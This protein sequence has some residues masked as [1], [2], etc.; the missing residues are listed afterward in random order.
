MTCEHI[1]QINPDVKPSTTE[2]CEDCLKMNPQG[3]W[4]HLRMCLIC[5]HI[6]CCDSSPNTHARKHFEETGHPIIESF[7]I[8][9]NDPKWRWCY[10]DNDYLD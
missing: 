3:T 4:V 7:T 5:G 8:D 10:V 2:G 6:G 1:K 9:S